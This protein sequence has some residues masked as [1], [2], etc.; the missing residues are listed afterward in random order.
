MKE[1]SALATKQ[2][3]EHRETAAD[4]GQAR[5]SAMG[6]W[7]QPDTVH[8][9]WEGQG[10]FP[11]DDPDP[12]P[13]IRQQLRDAND[14]PLAASVELAATRLEQQRSRVRRY[15]RHVE[16][17]SRFLPG[18]DQQGEAPSGRAS[19]SRPEQV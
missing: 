15:E 16:R 3:G 11:G 14:L 9:L 18:W 8:P 6:Y 7:H 2:R 13:S 5:R 4:A 19:F 17:R 12:R 10:G 1:G